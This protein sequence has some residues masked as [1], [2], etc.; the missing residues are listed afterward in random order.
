M[1]N[2]QTAFTRQIQQ[3]S[4]TTAAA[5]VTAANAGMNTLQGNTIGTVDVTGAPVGTQTVMPNSIT[6]SP[7]TAYLD[8]TPALNFI[9]TVEWVENIQLT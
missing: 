8:A 9:C 3:Y 6:C 2:K 5:V 4:N 1:A 7:V